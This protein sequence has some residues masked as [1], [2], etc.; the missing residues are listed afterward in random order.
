M[1][2]ATW[3]IPYARNAEAAEAMALRNGLYLAHCLGCGRVIVESDCLTVVEAINDQG[4]YL[5]SEAAVY[6]ECVQLARDFGRIQFQFCNREANK[7]ADCLA[8]VALESGA[9]I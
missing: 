5:G 1:A 9:N 7:V 2:A 4:N 3:L 8:K 6:T